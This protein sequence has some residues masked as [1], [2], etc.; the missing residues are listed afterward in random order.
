MCEYLCGSGALLPTC[1]GVRGT[2]RPEVAKEE[3]SEQWLNA[4]E[5]HQ[6]LTHGLSWLICYLL[7]AGGISHTQSWFL[8]QA[9]LPRLEASAG[10]VS[11]RTESWLRSWEMEIFQSDPRSVT[12]LYKGRPGWTGWIGWALNLSAPAFPH[13]SKCW[14]EI[15]GK[16]EGKVMLS[17]ACTSPLVDIEW[18]CFTSPVNIPCQFPLPPPPS[19]SGSRIQK[20]PRSGGTLLIR[21][22]TPRFYRDICQGEAGPGLGSHSPLEQNQD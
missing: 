8:V 17:M 16:L 11:W 20:L 22:P 6:M 2:L 15:K 1:L 12:G 14:G 3:G 9:W 5:V 10:G 7:G 21:D 18:G 19:Q 4:P 13:L